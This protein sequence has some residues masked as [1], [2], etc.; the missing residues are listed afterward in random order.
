MRVLLDTREKHFHQNPYIADLVA[1]VGADHVDGFSWRRA[2]TGRYDVVHIHWPEWLVKHGR[3]G[4]GLAM[5][6]LLSVALVR[7][8]LTRTPILRTVHN[9]NPH[10]KVSPWGRRLMDRIERQAGRRVWLSVLDDQADKVGATDAVIPHPDYAPL[11]HRLGAEAVPALAASQ[12]LC[13]GSL[14]AYRRFEEVAQAASS[15]HGHLLIAGSASDSEYAAQLES[16]ADRS[17]GRVTVRRGRL[18]DPDLVATIQRSDVVFVP[19][20]DLYNSGVIFL[21]LTLQRPVAL[22]DGAAAARLAAE[23]GDQWVRR[24]TGTLDADSF[25]RIVAAPAPS[26]PA[27][28]A[29]R[30][31][32]AVGEAH[33]RI[34]AAMGA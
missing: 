33:R 34:Y 10:A 27:H 25:D 16:I 31:W 26:T 21:A 17:E 24:W 22:R 12:G 18:S 2:L 15:A 29:E 20:D 32:S 7:W 23:Y 3:P 4:V 13:F 6:A 11:L 30:E 8:R 14:T 28:S 1:S 19:Y 5:R 9:R